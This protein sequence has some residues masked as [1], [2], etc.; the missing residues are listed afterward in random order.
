M[1]KVSSLNSTLKMLSVFVAGLA[2]AT[3]GWWQ[4]DRLNLS[5]GTGSAIDEVRYGFNTAPNERCNPGDKEQVV[6]K[7]DE[8]KIATTTTRCN[9]SRRYVVPTKTKN[10]VGVTTY[11]VP[12]RNSREEIAYG[13][14][15]EDKKVEF[16]SEFDRVT[17]EISKMKRVIPSTE[18][19]KSVD[20]QEYLKYKKELDGMA[21]RCLPS[22]TN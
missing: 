7:Y 19:N 14:V 1:K 22:K 11:M 12:V 20:Y 4:S 18:L 8:C 13:K 2:V 9:P 17:T 3:L 21:K 5:F 15:V 10:G 6:R 16:K